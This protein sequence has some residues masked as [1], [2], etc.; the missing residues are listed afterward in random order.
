MPDQPPVAGGPPTARHPH[1]DDVSREVRRWYTTTFP[2][3][4]VHVEE[5]WFGF[6]GKLRPNQARLVLTVDDPDDVARS[7]AAARAA[8]AG[9]EFDVWVDDR[10]RARRL[11]A[12][13]QRDGY[14][15]RDPII[16]LALVGPL[17]S[18]KPPPGE[19]RIDDVAE[20]Q[21]ES[22]ARVKLQ[23]FA[24]SETEPSATDLAAE[25]A[26]RRA[27][28]PIAKYQLGAIDGQ[29]ATALGYH[30]GPDQLAFLL[31]TRVPFRHR[32]IAQAMLH[33]WVMQGRAA[34]CRSLLINAQEGS[35]PEA[36]YRRLGF[37]DEV[38]WHR[39]YSPSQ[40]P[41]LS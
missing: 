2:E 33:R 36:L 6:I 10:R 19:L 15:P 5:H 29:P 20:D 40:T 14:A 25:M 4:G 32:G 18:L 23:A 3:I 31:G 24:D 27:M 21:L 28:L 26:N 12:A 16:H 30:T 37:R 7:L 9:R 35:R 1:H 8:C 11:D 34:G 13:I 17:V 41:P 22:W 38:Y 39:S